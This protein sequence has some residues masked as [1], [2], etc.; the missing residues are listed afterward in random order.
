VRDVQIGLQV[1][2][3]ITEFSKAGHQD[4]LSN[5]LAAQLKD[6]ATKFAPVLGK[7]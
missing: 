6:Y 3:G 4:A 1:L 5:K 7:E 2:N